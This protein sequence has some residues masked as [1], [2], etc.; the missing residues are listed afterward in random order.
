MTKLN[1]T[2]NHELATP[3][4]LQGLEGMGNEN[5]TAAE[6]TVPRIVVLQALSPQLSPS[7]AK[8]VE[9]ARAG[10]LYNT[11]TGEVHKEMNV[12]N[13]Y[14]SKEYVL[15]RSRDLGGGYKGTFPNMDEAVT[16]MQALPDANDYE[17]IEQHVHYCLLLT[18]DGKF[19]GEAAIPM[20]ST[21]LKVSR[22]WNSRIHMAAKGFPRFSSIWNL[23]TVSE[24]NL[25]GNWYNLKVAPVG[26]ITETLVEPAK[27]LY[28][29]VSS[30]V[31]TMAAEEEAHVEQVDY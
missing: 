28:E 25:K 8:Y 11:V 26:W 6:L 4:F 3:S 17:V 12:V 2:K 30:G 18:P 16:A 24:K 7:D 27:A 1:T 21:K 19:A 29:A 22:E 15:W 5:V 9:S 10:M 14:F 20:S 13:T 31:K 23:S